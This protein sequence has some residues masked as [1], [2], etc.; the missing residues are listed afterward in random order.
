MN[1]KEA[2]IWARKVLKDNEV[3]S[4]EASADFLLRQLLAIDKAQMLTHPEEKIPKLQELKFR[5]WVKKRSKHEPVWYITGKIEFMELDLA[6]NQSVLIP[7]PET[8]LLVEKI[9]AQYKIQNTKYKILDVGTGSG[10]IILSLAKH[11]PVSSLVAN[12]GTSSVPSEGDP[13]VRKD[14]IC[15]FASDISSTALDTAKKNKKNN[16]IAPE[17]K[18]VEGDLFGPWAGEKFD[19][20]VANLPYV[21]HE[22]MATLAFDLTHYEPR[23]ALDGGILGLEVYKRFIEELPNYLNPG[24]KV[25]ME[26]GYDQG[27][28][29]EDFVHKYLPKAKVETLGD[30][31][32]I[33]RI[34]VIE[35]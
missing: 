29:I 35:T 12:P 3:D 24:A 32:Q 10:T 5:R 19:L 8:E 28:Y 33:D 23:V 14:N 11:L 2:S 18:F 15:F 9:L 6:V 7:R 20:V 21:P 13:R 30:Y 26:I 1:I 17:I 22:D 31:R 4:P 27:R 16:N 34:V 25:F